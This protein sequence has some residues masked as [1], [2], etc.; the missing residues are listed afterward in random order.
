MNAA[1]WLLA[2]VSGALIPFQ[3]AM[4]AE[5]G[6]RLGHP[7]FATCL[8]FLVGFLLLLAISAPLAR[9]FEGT[10]NVPGSPWWAWMGG[11]IGATFVF[12]AA[13]FVPKLGAVPFLVITLAGQLIASILM[14]QFGW[15]N[16]SVR[17]V[18]TV[19][20]VGLIVVICGA[21][22]VSYGDRFFG[23][24]REIAAP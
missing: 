2:L 15:M 3:S 24:P 10:R 13:I 1:L 19:R 8:N 18:S 16:L 11:A 17:P 7:V 4:N 5:S 23:A 22:L 21:L 6:R 20:W 12:T 9:S 14:D